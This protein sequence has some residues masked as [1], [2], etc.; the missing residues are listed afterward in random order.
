MFEMTHYCTKEKDGSVHVQ[1]AVMGHL[2]QHHVYTNLRDFKKWTVVADVKASAI[3][4]LKC[5]PC[6]CGLEPGEVR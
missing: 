2:G 1:N 4:W 6:G 5:D 3:K